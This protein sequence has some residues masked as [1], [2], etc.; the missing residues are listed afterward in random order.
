MAPGAGGAW[1][2]PRGCNGCGAR[3]SREEKGA[4]VLKARAP[5]G[6]GSCAP[7]KKPSLG[8]GRYDRE[9]RRR[10]A[11]VAANDGWRCA[12]RW[13]GERRAAPTMGPLCVTH[14]NA[15]RD[16]RSTGHWPASACG[17]GQV[18]RRADVRG[19]ATSCARARVPG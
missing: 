6:R 5:W 13:V 9:G 19:A 11:A 18:R 15:Q 3:C 4:W 14:R 16:A 1:S 2:S 12:V 8:M 10:A 7:R 17:Y